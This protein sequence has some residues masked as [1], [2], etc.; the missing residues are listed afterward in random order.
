MTEL[1][2]TPVI[3][4]RD[5]KTGEYVTAEYAEAN[6]DTTVSETETGSD[7][8]LIETGVMEQ[9]QAAQDKFEHDEANEEAIVSNTEPDGLPDA[10]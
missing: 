9:V 8:L 4:Y 2:E 6:P 5:A 7:D 1:P 3:Q 10:E